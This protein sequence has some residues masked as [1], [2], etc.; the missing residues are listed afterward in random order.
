[1][2]EEL[3]QW[4]GAPVEEVKKLFGDASYRTY[5]RVRSAHRSFVLMELPEGKLSA[6]EEIT[7]LASKPSEMPF[8]NVQRF[9][10]NLNV[11]VPTIEK[12]SETHRWVLLEDLGDTK[13]FDLVAKTDEKTLLSWYQKALDLLIELKNKTLHPTAMHQQ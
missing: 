4:L 1:M 10:K 8:L 5:Y 7:N 9:L 3:E 13:L 2:K 12:Y 6:S 11:S